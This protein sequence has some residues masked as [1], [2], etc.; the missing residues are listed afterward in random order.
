MNLTINGRQVTVDDSFRD[1]PREEQE[2]TVEHISDSMPATAPS[3]VIAG[4]VHGLMEPVQGYA[5][6][7]KRFAGVTS[8]RAPEKDYV[9][10]NVTNGSWN[11]ANWNVDQIPQK[12]AE[13]APSAI[14]DVA[15]GVV[16]A[17][18]GKKIGGAK[19]ALIGG[20]IGSMLS[21]TARTAGD[22]A[23]DVTVARTGDVNAP[24]STD[25]LIRG[26]S[27]ATA[28]SAA[29]ALLPTR[30][31]PGL[32]PL[33]TVGTEG[34][35]D[36]AKRLVG[37][38]V[39][40]GAG[41]VGGNA[42][43]QAGVTGNVDP[44]QFPEA[45]VGGAATGATLGSFRAMGDAARAVNLREFGGDNL[46]A[47]KNYATRLDT[48]GQGR[49]GKAT[50]DQVAQETVKS[51]LKNELG[52]A[53]A[54]VRKAKPNLSP[55]ADNAL[56]RAQS[57]RPLSAADIKLIDRETAGTPDGA[58]AAFLARTM[59]MAQLN[60]ERGS[61]SAKGW[62]GGLSGSMDSNLRFLLN[63][64]RAIGGALGTAAGMHIMGLGNPKIALGI[65]AGYLGA[66]A[67]DKVAG[68]RSPAKSFAE[69]F[70]DHQ[71]QLRMP[72]TPQPQAPAP[73]APPPQAAPW[74]PRPPMSG[75]TGPTVSPPAAP[76]GVPNAPW[77]PRPLATTSV[78]PVAAPAAP[79]PI[80]P[81]T[82]PW[83]K[84]NVA[85]LP[86]I[87]PTALTMLKSQ[88][89][90]GLP[91][92]AAPAAPITPGTAPWQKP[93]VTELPNFSPMAL[94]ALNARM[95]ENA[96]APAR[97][98]QAETEAAKAAQAQARDA[99]KQKTQTERAQAKADQAQARAE[100][101]A[102]AVAQA[103]DKEAAK[104][105]VVKAKAAAAQAKEAAKLEQAKVKAAAA[106]LRQATVKSAPAKTISKSNGKVDAAPEEAPAKFEPFFEEQL[107]PKGITAKEY[108]DREA[109]AYGGSSPGYKA[110]AERSAQA[111]INA[112]DDLNEQFPKYKP[113]FDNTLR[114]LHKIGPNPTEIKAAVDHF[115][116]HVP[117]DVAAAMREAYTGAP[118]APKASEAPMKTASAAAAKKSDVKRS[119]APKKKG[120]PLGVYMDGDGWTIMNE[121]TRERT[122]HYRTSDEAHAAKR[123]MQGKK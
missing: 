77:G 111:R 37:T 43:T 98:A 34:V 60:Q 58:N 56:Q 78:P 116:S 9:P 5:E 120:P 73:T 65:G 114:Q 87:S 35:V 11:P 42:I 10:A 53:A 97:Q 52:D 101:A 86:N 112:T 115:A 89:D 85:E 100:K 81:G 83:Q 12:I 69:H 22:T 67:L 46:D 90:K 94:S 57:D 7:L 6:T 82:L 72:Q 96:S 54:A 51:D 21:G 71:A 16:G 13:L 70:A 39:L 50:R 25:D 107:Y 36:A 63:P 30:L 23:K 103:K 108:A 91:A 48:A 24:S 75:P 18:I 92:P 61:Y 26:G 41:A 121:D 123:R 104:A 29:T 66:R 15:T 93:T 28:A 33:R 79:A 88:L 117:D 49:L 118:P 4:A 31:I 109:E 55:D 110:K 106:M 19:G 76:M 64:T 8:G 99:Q 27:T 2:A 74:G 45:A 1:L 17:K 47:S 105:E 113:T 102:A 32:S 59:R 95:V 119:T 44:S 40:G 122:G 3:G 68:T 84:P 14:P 38:S 80:T 62:A 20:L